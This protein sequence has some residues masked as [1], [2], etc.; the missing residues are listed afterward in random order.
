MVGA[1]DRQADLLEEA[2]HLVA[3]VRVLVGGGDGEVAAL[4][5]HLV[6]HVAAL[7]D[8][9]RVPVRLGGV[10]G[11]EG[12]VGAD[13]VADVVEEIELG[14]GAD[15]A[16]VR[17][18][19]GAQVGLGLGGHL[20]RVAREGLV[21]E[22]VDDREVDDQG[23]AIAERIDEGGG[24][25]RDELHVGLVDGGESAHRGAVEHETVRQ[26]GVQ[27]FAHGDRE[28]LL[29]PGDVAEAHVDEFDVLLGDKVCDLFGG[30]EHERPSLWESCTRWSRIG[31]FATKSSI[32]PQVA[33]ARIGFI[34]Q[35]FHDIEHARRG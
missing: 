3:H 11:E 19:S 21:G 34:I 24:D 31:Q 29:N 2:A 4:D 17:D 9:S 30:G 18:A 23:L 1:L 26:S 10:D 28:V 6:A 20:A 15:E 14:F 16:L 12:V 13:L 7:F 27:E 5:G 33:S 8:A 25:I 35:R 22:G 32:C